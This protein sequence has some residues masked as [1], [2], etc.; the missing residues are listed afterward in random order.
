MDFFVTVI[1]CFC[2]FFNQPCSK[3]SSS[4]DFWKDYLHL[5]KNLFLTQGLQIQ[6]NNNVWHTLL[7]L[8]VRKEKQEG[9]R[10][11]TLHAEV[12][13]DTVHKLLTLWVKPYFPISQARDGARKCPSQS[14]G[15]FEPSSISQ[16]KDAEIPE[17]VHINET[18]LEKL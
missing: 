16:V 1:W 15:N 4:G 12:S 17:L 6:L 7:R 3:K 5:S 14:M 11:Q 8:R 13:P 18:L 2:F 10:I 9:P